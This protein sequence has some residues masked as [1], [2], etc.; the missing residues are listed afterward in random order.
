MKGRLGVIHGADRCLTVY[1]DFEMCAMPMVRSQTPMRIS[2]V[3]R[4]AGERTRIFER[5]L[6]ARETASL[7][8]RF[9]GF[10]SWMSET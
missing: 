9:F 4:R 3:R 10:L 7:I 2:A 5:R 6:S 8:V 1:V